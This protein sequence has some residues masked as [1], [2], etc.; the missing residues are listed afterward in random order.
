MN[1]M[2]IVIIFHNIAVKYY[3]I[4]FIAMSAWTTVIQ[5]PAWTMGCARSWMQATN[6]HAQVATLAPIV[7]VSITCVKYLWEWVLHLWSICG[8]E[9]YICEVSMT[10]SVT[11]VKY[12]WQWVWHLWSIYSSECDNCEVYVRRSV[13]IV[14][15]LWQWVWNLWSA[16]NSECDI[17]EVSMTVSVTI[18]KYL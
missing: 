9:N 3:M 1:S 4:C 17:C 8:S 15:Y 11:F 2:I 13:T 6:V 7:K 14:K 12:L 5:T 16:Y 10:V 18:V